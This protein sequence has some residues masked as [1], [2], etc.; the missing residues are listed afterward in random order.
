MS[1]NGTAERLSVAR[2]A[3]AELIDIVRAEGRPGTEGWYRMLLDIRD[4]LADAGD[5]TD[6]GNSAGAAGERALAD[7]AAMFDALYAGPR[8]FSEFHIWRTDEPERL[9]ANRRLSQLIDELES[10][11]RAA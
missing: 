3:V 8:N 5:A 11:L 2:Q 4:T 9:A 7:A 6:S 10:A 1:A